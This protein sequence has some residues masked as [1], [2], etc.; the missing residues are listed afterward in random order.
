LRWSLRLLE[1]ELRDRPGQ[2][3]Y[4]IEY[5]KT[6]LL[7]NDPKG[8]EVLAQAVEQVLAVRKGPTPPSPDVQRLFE[9]LLTV[10]PAQSRS[11]LSRAETRA[12]A[13][14][15]FPK[16]P[17]LL[18]QIA[19]QHF[20]ANELHQAARLLEK[21]VELGKTGAYDRSEG[22]EPG[23]IGEPAMMNLAI[24]H[25]RLGDLDKAEV[26]LLQLLNGAKFREKAAQNLAVVQ[27]QRVQG[28]SGP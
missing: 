16:S 1:L 18:W 10:D 13:L 17:G 11:R 20:Q 8:H 15:W 22:F 27:A 5:G 21:L 24:C 28:T 19:L 12:L 9:Y 7:A 25:M 4:L 6:L 23:I 14:R 2:L 3:H 26:C